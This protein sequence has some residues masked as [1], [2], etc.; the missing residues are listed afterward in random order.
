MSTTFF[1][2]LAFAPTEWNHTLYHCLI[3]R[4]IT[5]HLGNCPDA[6]DA[7][8][9]PC[10]MDNVKLDHNKVSISDCHHYLFP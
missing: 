10:P 2:T 1:S 7:Q 9:F 6:E 4:V 3:F 5:N 8:Y